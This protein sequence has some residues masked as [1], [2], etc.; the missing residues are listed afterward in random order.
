MLKPVIIG[1]GF[2]VKK[3][4]KLVEKNTMKKFLL[5]LNLSA[6]L[7]PVYYKAQTATSIA[8]GNWTSPFT[9]DCTCVPVNG[10]N[11]TINH[12]VTLNTSM[13]FSS[14]GVT[15][16][17]SGSLIQ[18][19][20]MNRDIWI[21]GGSFLNNGVADFRYFLLSTGTG[22]NTGDFRISAFK[23]DV[24]F[25]N[26]GGIVMDSMHIVAYFD[27]AGTITGDS[28][29][30][31]NYI[32]NYGRI[33]IQWLTNNLTLDNLRYLKSFSMTNNGTFTNADSLVLNGSLWNAGIFDNIDTATVNITH[34]FYNYHPS[35]TAM[36]TNN[37]DV[38]VSGSWYNNSTVVGSVGG[39]FSVADTSS[40]SA[41]MQGAFQFCDQ[42]PPATTPFVDFNSGFID[43]TITW[44]TA[45]GIPQK[46]EQL[47]LVA[48]PNPS[49]GSITVKGN[50]NNNIVLRDIAGR[51]VL[52]GKLTKENDYSL[53]V[54]N[55]PEGIYFCSFEN[56]TVF[57]KIVV[58]K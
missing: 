42:T 58:M 45:V 38:F 15:I 36:F 30:N 11:V 12:N 56:S 39:Y 37:G 25:I 2:H 17:N 20:A 55:L 50:R 34:N 51:V 14:G 52:E 46:T 48:F 44:C 10:Y 16:G 13:S 5:F 26:S 1:S 35:Q 33:N 7:I 41:T 57:K 43:A 23:N 53:L 19:A 4:I 29:L 27:N 47:E 22:E 8:N 54:N 40:N 24:M 18:D 3:I 28:L 31:D 32:L 9:W 21:N 6:F 49:S